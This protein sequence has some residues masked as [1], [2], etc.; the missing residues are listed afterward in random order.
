MAEKK[1]KK[2][3]VGPAVSYVDAKQGIKIDDVEVGAGDGGKVWGQIDITEEDYAYLYKGSQVVHKLDKAYD[4]TN[5]NKDYFLVKLLNEANLT[6]KTID[7]GEKISKVYADFTTP[8][9][10]KADWL[11]ADIRKGLDALV[12]G[13]GFDYHYYQTIILYA[14]RAKTEQEIESG[15]FI[16]LISADGAFEGNNI[17]YIQDVSQQKWEKDEKTENEEKIAVDEFKRE[18]LEQEAYC[19]S[20]VLHIKGGQ[21][22]AAVNLLFCYEN[23]QAAYIKQD[24]SGNSFIAYT[25]I[26]AGKIYGATFDTDS[27]RWVVEVNADGEAI[28]ATAATIN[29]LLNDG[30]AFDDNV[31]ACEFVE[32]TLA[33]QGGKCLGN[34]TT[35]FELLFSVNKEF[36]QDR[37]KDLLVI[38][39]PAGRAPGYY[40]WYVESEEEEEGE[41][42][43]TDCGAYIWN[44]VIQGVEYMIYIPDEEEYLDTLVITTARAKI[45]AGLSGATYQRMRLYR[46]TINV[47]SGADATVK[48]HLS[49]CAVNAQAGDSSIEYL[50]HSDESYYD[51]T[52]EVQSIDWMLPVS[53]QVQVGGT[54]FPAVR[55][56][57]TWVADEGTTDTGHRALKVRYIKADF[58]TEDVVLIDDNNKDNYTVTDFRS[59]IASVATVSS[60]ELVLKEAALEAAD[61]SK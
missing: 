20:Y 25:D 5:F 14:A 48:C 42:L 18:D 50:L 30:V 47:T 39:R 15:K 59:V 12:S 55:I 6:G 19:L 45:S 38:A 49:L 52:A 31:F 51:K 28:E 32:D 33:K 10:A 44:I 16:P 23:S 53:G 57:A 1:F 46:H 37:S 4:P 13:S 2:L 35:N 36:S 58:T 26:E 21:N 61:L 24:G 40:E 3:Q 11:K 17:V 54:A 43:S 60:D 56:V 7:A 34:N 29:G 8:A 27:L 9:G 41:W 22:V